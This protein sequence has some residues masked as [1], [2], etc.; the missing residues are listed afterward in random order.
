MRYCIS[1][2]IL[3]LTC[4]QAQADT[5][6]LRPDGQGDAARQVSADNR[7]VELIEFLSTYFK[8]FGIRFVRSGNSC[9][10]IQYNLSGQ[11]VENK[12]VVAFTGSIMD[13]STSLS[14]YE[15]SGRLRSSSLDQDDISAIITF[16]TFSE[17]RLR[18]N[19]RARCQLLPSLRTVAHTHAQRYLRQ[20]CIRH[21]FILA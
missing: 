5:Y 15:V 1:A 17:S 7:A 19:R 18:D 14:L 8:K 20:Q 4:V 11:S 9:L 3:M 6:C 10:P 12:E 2:L 13:G 16:V 21:K